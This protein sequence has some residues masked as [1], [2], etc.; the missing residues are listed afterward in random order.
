[1][2]RLSN[3]LYH[4]HDGCNRSLGLINMDGVTALVRKELL[5]VSR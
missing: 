3:Q 4:L 1:M 2:Y 5:A